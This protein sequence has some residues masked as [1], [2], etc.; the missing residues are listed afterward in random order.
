MKCSQRL[1][2]P[3]DT[4]DTVKASA[5]GLGVD[6]RSA[7][8]RR[9]IVVFAGPLSENIAHLIDGDLEIEFLE[10]FDKKVPGLLVLVGEGE[11]L[12]AASGRGADFGH[13]LQ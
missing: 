8:D 2:G 7:H 1:K 9:K 13:L 11:P 6:V 12:H 3:H 5:F 4:Q 10:P